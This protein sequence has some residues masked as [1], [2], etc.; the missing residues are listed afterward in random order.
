MSI[1]SL[2]LVWR[3][4]KS[5]LYFH[6]GTLTYDGFEYIFEYT[7]QSQ[8]E[9]KV[10]DAIQYGYNLHPAFPVLNETYKS[11]KLF[12]AFARR[13]PSE[14]RLDYKE[15][16]KRLSL[17]KDADSMDLLKATRGM[18]GGNPY[19]FDEPL[20][21][22]KDNILSTSFYVSGMR[23]QDL[24]E[25]WYYNIRQGEVL[26]LTPDDG[27]PFDSNAVQIL[28]NDEKRLGYVPGIFSKAIKALL[29]REVEMKL[30]VEKI[31]PT[32]AAQW[33]VQVCFKSKLD[34]TQ[35]TRDIQELQGL[36]MQVA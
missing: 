5:K 31:N 15:V 30:V 18:I 8:A 6:V 9:R 25:D 23:Y 7:Y 19:F 10:M 35:S 28:T 12:S 17:P 14:N 24:S 20:R 36:V 27:N 1:K 29:E 4:A 13:I 32:Y 3:D 21:L 16:L 11:T 26:K 22:D 33:W 2:L 34:Q